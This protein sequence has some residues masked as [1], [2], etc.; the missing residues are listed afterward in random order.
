MSL[1]SVSVGYQQDLARARLSCVGCPR[2]A[3]LQGVPRHIQL[4]NW[5]CQSSLALIPG[6]IVGIVPSG[7]MTS[8]CGSFFLSFFFPGAD[9]RTFNYCADP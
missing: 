9:V 5:L 3:V 2:W 6:G 8:A 4:R 1:A 7:G